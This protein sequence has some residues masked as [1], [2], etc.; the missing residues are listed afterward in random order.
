M[1]EGT[2]INPPPTVN[3]ESSRSGCVKGCSHQK[4]PPLTLLLDLPLEKAL[5]TK[6]FSA[7]RDS[8]KASITAQ[9]SR[10]LK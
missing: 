4:S 1:V 3:F 8:L 7:G 2:A 9:A 5:F 10:D 6:V